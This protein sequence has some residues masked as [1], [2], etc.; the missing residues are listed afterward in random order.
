MYRGGVSK[1]RVKG[2]Q[3]LEDSSG[4]EFGN[5]T[6][7]VS[8]LVAG[9]ETAFR[10][11]AKEMSTRFLRWVERRRNTP[12]DAEEVINDA[13]VKMIT[14]I[15]SFRAGRGAS[16]WSWAYKVVER[17]AID[18]FRKADRQTPLNTVSLEVLGEHA[19]AIR[20]VAPCVL[21]A[22]E[23]AG[24]PSPE[25]AA[26]KEGLAELRERDR[27]ILELHFQV[28]MTDEDVAKRLGIEN[29]DNVRKYRWRALQRLRKILERYPVFQD[30]NGIGTK[31]HESAPRAGKSLVR[32]AG[33]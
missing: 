11:L 1:S 19:A 3:R 25:V 28:R 32:R 8:G 27:A 2:V 20:E 15:K 31:R 23:D 14:R 6:E 22:E 17:Q 4:T 33:A 26:L 10:I 9:N 30:W 13:T 7:L 5:E 16:F 12:E 24:E 21:G 29:V 18:H